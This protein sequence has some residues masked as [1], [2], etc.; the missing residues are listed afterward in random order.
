M[1]RNL[2]E[3]QSMNITPDEFYN[4]TISY[5][6]NGQETY[7]GDYST[8]AFYRLPESLY[9]IADRYDY[10]WRVVVRKVATKSPEGKPDGP[11]ISPESEVRGFHWE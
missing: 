8:T 7:F 5:S 2:L 10:K 3:W 1:A 4:I 9:G 6:R 11:A